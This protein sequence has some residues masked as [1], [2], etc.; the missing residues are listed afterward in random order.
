MV[1]QNKVHLC[2]NCVNW[3][4]IGPEEDD[5]TCDFDKF[6]TTQIEKA[7]LFVAEL[8]DCKEFEYKEN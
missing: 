2:S 7:Q 1:K 6:P 4:E 8:F 5:V 3:L